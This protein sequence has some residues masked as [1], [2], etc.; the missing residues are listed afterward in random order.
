MRK[1]TGMELSSLVGNKQIITRSGIKAVII[2]ESRGK[3][4]GYVHSPSLPKVGYETEKWNLDGSKYK[5]TEHPHD[6]F[7]NV[8]SC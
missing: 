6:L 8:E 4:I 2:G 7:I 3:F 5:G 1:L